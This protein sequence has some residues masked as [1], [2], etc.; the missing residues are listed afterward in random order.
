MKKELVALTL[1][2]SVTMNGNAQVYPG[3]SWARLPTMDLY[4]TGTMNAYARA[5]AETAARRKR[6]FEYYSDLAV[7]AYNEEQWSYAIECVN[8][9]L[10]TQ[11]YSGL[12][13]YIRGYALEQLGDEKA[14]MK[15]YKK[16]KKYGSEAAA[17]ALE[18]LK[19]RRKRK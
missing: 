2:W 18:S 1:A 9:A 7:E 12:V 8:N 13:F 19:D 14:A 3:D 10:N 17:S 11:Y 6:L 4:D 15:D 5:V 16:G